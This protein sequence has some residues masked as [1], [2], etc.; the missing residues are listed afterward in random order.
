MYAFC[1]LDQPTSVRKFCARPLSI[2]TLSN[3]QQEKMTYKLAKKQ[4]LLLH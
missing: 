4:G 2:S 3:G 1:N